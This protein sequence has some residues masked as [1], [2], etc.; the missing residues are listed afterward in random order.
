MSRQ[1]EQWMDKANCVGENPNFF[2]VN[3]NL[4]YEENKSNMDAGIE[5]C[6]ECPVFMM[7]K[8]D[9][10]PDDLVHTVRAGEYPSV[11]AATIEAK[12]KEKQCQRGHWHAPGRCPECRAMSTAK[13]NEKAKQRRAANA[14]KWGLAP[15]K[16]NAPSDKPMRHSDWPAPGEGEPHAVKVGGKHYAWREERGVWVRTH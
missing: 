5:V 15:R 8:E 6:L 12:T 1:Y 13:A 11:F 14:E 10:E 2:S 7:C 16:R 3:E 9:A 4:T